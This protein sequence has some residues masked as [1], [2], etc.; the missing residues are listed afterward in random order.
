MG[1]LRREKPYDRTRLLHR[2]ARAARAGK[3]RGPGPKR[4]AI[5]FY[6]QVLAVEP[7]NPDLHR[8]IAP[9]LALTRQTESAWSSYRRAAEALRERGFVD[10]AIGVYREAV[11]F[12][13]RQV[14]AWKRLAELE[15]ERGRRRDAVATLLAGQRQFRSRHTRQ[16]AIIL[17]TEAHKLDPNDPAVTFDLA[18]LLARTG[19]RGRAMAI[20]DALLVARPEVEP[21]IRG[22]QFRIA[23]GIASAW[24]CLR[25][26]WVTARS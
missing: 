19:A 12:L 5:G 20:L 3:W 4:K 8:K 7:D 18:S 16:H 10:R 22:R 25:A 14:A 2:A 24:R 9:L 13:P 23:P 11:R 1:L 21:A 17:L 15:L 6:R 26:R